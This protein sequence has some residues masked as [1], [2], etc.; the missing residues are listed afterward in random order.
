MG[1]AGAVWPLVSVSARAME[2]SDVKDEGVVRLN[3]AQTTL[4]LTAMIDWKRSSH[5]WRLA[6]LTTLRHARLAGLADLRTTAGGTCRG[7][8]RMYLCEAWRR[9]R[10]AKRRARCASWTPGK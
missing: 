10:R 8:R 4:G 2:L 9:V 3:I 7:L 6:A 5:I 1:A